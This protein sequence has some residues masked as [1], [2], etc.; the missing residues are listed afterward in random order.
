MNLGTTIS[1]AFS[2]R[3]LRGHLAIA[4]LTCAVAGC[5]PKGPAYERPAAPSAPA[6]N[7]PAPWRPSDPKDAIPKGEWWTIFH[8]DELSGLVKAAITANQTLEGARDQYQQSRALTA[9]SLSAQYPHVSI[10]IG[11]QDQRVS[12][13]SATGNGTA[14]NQA[15]FSLPVSVSY[16]VDLFGKRMKSIES[17]QDT[18]QASAAE[19]ENVQLVLIAQLASDYFTVRQLDTELGIL[20][21][22]VSSLEQAVTLVRNRHDGGVASGLDVAQEETLLASTR[23]QATL[24]R[25]QRDQ[26]EHAIAVLVGQPAPLFHLATRELTIE[27]PAFDTGLPSDLL[28]RRP[29]IAEAERQMAAA[30]ARIGVARAAYFPSLNLFGT[31]GWQSGNLLKIFDVPSMVWAV[32]ASL[33]Q[34]VF[35]GGAR[36]AQTDF[37]QA[38]FNG[39][40]AGYRQ[41]VLQALAE[42][43]DALAGLLVLNDAR[44][45]QADAVDA[46]TRALNIA[47][48]R[49]TGGLV[50]SL[51]VVTA[52]QVL[53]DNQRL[54]AQI[55]GER[56]VTTVQLVKALGGGWDASSLAAARLVK[57]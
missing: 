5:A 18:L 22:T 24:V 26:F 50:T 10:P 45:T 28:E 33:T 13:N 14:L 4:L 25:Q 46:A 55:Q 1:A 6:W 20:T 42:V 41:T 35:T 17:A 30:N 47:T 2:R 15:S 38:E 34:D 36:K 44:T 3:G 32:G 54:A 27:P 52:Q 56:L 21:R 37:A 29:D 23:T 51:D 40:V 9:L 49:Y 48:D 53:L 8:D 43:Q 19:L 11:V 57:H 39:M 16:E 12:G 31:D 7:T